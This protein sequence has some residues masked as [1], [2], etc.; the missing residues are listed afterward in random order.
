MNIQLPLYERYMKVFNWKENPFNFKILPELFVGYNKEV[1]KLI[2]YLNNG[3][4]FSLLIGPT[5]SG[6]TTLLKWI[7]KNSKDL[8]YIYYL[9]KPPKDPN[10]WVNI[11]KNFI[12]PSLISRL[13]SREN[14][15]LYNL[16]EIV[17]KKLKNKK[18]I[19]LVDECHEATLESLEWLRTL[20]DQIENLYLVLAGLPTFETILKEN[21]ETFIKRINLK[22]ELTN[23]TKSETRELIK[24]RIE[25]V[26][27]DDIKPFTHDIIDFIYETTG[28][29]PR[30]ILRVCN[31]LVQ[32]AS[33]KNI[34]IIDQEFVKEIETPPSRVSLKIINSL[35][36]KQKVILEILSKNDG[37]TPSEIVSELNL[38]NY[39]DKE[40]AVRSVNN[41]L[42]RLMKD[43]LIIRRKR[44]KAYE[45]LISERIQTLM[46]NA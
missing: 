34:T 4:K 30:E 32:K 45:Y 29:F 10:D 3:S 42:K 41:I 26:G 27:G 9:P 7:L 20:T 19:L 1:N 17:N 43:K 23:L 35:P 36:Q 37:L 22:I 5:G 40:N 39:K 33:E 38:N 2:N 16:S 44:G 46:V 31:D 24:K 13:I 18:L 8:K 12:K 14:M 21:L 11:F 25:W 15:N 6:K 28:G